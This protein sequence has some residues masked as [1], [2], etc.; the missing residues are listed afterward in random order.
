VAAASLVETGL[1]CCAPALRDNQVI[2]MPSRAVDEAWHGLILCTARYSASICIGSEPMQIRVADYSCFTTALRTYFRVP[3]KHAGFQPERGKVMAEAALCTTWG[4]VRPGR[5]K[6]ALE[7]YNETLQ[8]WARLQQDGRIERFDV[9]VLGP[10]GGDLGGFILVRGTAQQIDSLRRTD[11][12]LEL[13]QRVQ[14]IADRF[15]ITDAF[16][17]EGLA[18]VMGQYQKVVDELA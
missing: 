9:A 15:R 8:Y 12:Y 18:Q 6:L 2:G 14:M 1:R 3:T 10:T 11:E 13:T 16:V 5:E 17:D 4:D 7:V